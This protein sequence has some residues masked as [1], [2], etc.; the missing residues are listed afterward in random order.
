[1]ALLRAQQRGIIDRV[2]VLKQPLDVLAQ[3]VVAEVA[4]DEWLESDLFSIFK[5]AF[6]YRTLTP[7]VF[8]EV[9]TML[10]EGFTTLIAILWL[11]HAMFVGNQRV[12]IIAHSLDDAAV[13][14]RDKIWILGGNT[15]FIGQN[16]D[17]WTA[18]L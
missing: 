3:Q 11:D 1:M 2:E 7:E 4:Q 16:N 18:E 13:I 12:G 17:V 8:H 6:P 14:F 9:V 5:N 10:A 15:S